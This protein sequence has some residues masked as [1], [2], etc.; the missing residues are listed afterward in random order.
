MTKNA[1]SQS[2]GDHAR[3]IEGKTAET[4]FFKDTGEGKRT[5]LTGPLVLASS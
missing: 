4:T 5:T 3:Y 1:Y 2:R